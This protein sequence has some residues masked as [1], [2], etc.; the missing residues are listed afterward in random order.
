MGSMFS[1]TENNFG[2]VP[3]IVCSLLGPIGHLILRVVYL[4]G[5]LDKPWLFIP[6]TIPVVSIIPNLAMKYGYVKKGPGQDVID[7]WVLVP[8]ILKLL[9]AILLTVTGMG[10]N[11]MYNIIGLIIV[12]LST[13]IPNFK[14]IYD[15]CDKKVS[16]AK[17]IKAASDSYI[18]FGTAYFFPIFLNIISF[19]PIFRPL[20]FILDKIPGV[21]NVLWAMGF[22]CSYTITNMINQDDMKTYCE[23]PNDNKQKTLILCVISTVII[24]YNFIKNGLSNNIPSFSSNITGSYLPQNTMGSYLPQNTMGSYLPQNTMGS[25]LPQNTMGSYLSQNKMES[26]LPQN[27]MESYLP[28]NTMGS[29][30]PQNTMESYLP[31]NTIKQQY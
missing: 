17:I 9:I 13:F 18:E 25:Y 23:K 31:Q 11:M 6:G 26:Y 21:N 12:L 3:L 24:V 22:I 27:K 10:G 20:K 1:G 19:I 15:S 30:L 8:V 7:R 5:S 28:Q 2:W 4:N 29:Y 14:R 16:T